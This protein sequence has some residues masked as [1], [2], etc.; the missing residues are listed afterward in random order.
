M[1]HLS[2]A[3]LLADHL[4][5]A[6]TTIPDK[7]AIV[8]NGERWTWSTLNE[9]V[10]RLAAALIALNVQHGDRIGILSTTRP[11]YLYVYL[12]AARIGAVLVGFNIQFTPAEITRLA[13][14][15]RPVVMVAVDRVKGVPFAK[16]LLDL[17]ARLDYVKHVLVIG[18]TIP[19][20]LSVS[21]IIKSP[22]EPA[23][24][25]ALAE[26]A[27]LL[28]PD[29]PVLIVFTSGS[30]G[31]PKGAVLTHR[32]ILTTGRVQARQFGLRPSDRVLQNKP[33]NHVGGSINLTIP[34]LIVGATLVFMDHFHPIRALEMVRDE[35]ITVLA[36]VPTMF[37]MEFNLPDFADYDLSSVRLAIVGGA[38]TPVPIMHRIMDIAET[39]ITGFGMTE[40]GGYI[41][42][43]SPD[44]PPE[45]I[46][47][48]VGR[49]A[50]EYELRIVD[51]A[52]QP[53]PPGSVG[54]VALRGDCLLK[55][56]F[57]DP[58]ATI[59][60]RDEEGW[61]YTGDVGTL[62]VHGYLSLV[63]RLKEMYISG[64]YNVYP[65]EIEQHLAQYPGV[66]MVAV[67]G[68]TDPVMG[69]VGVAFVTLMPG[70][71]AADDDLRQFCASGLAEYKIPRRFQVID[72]F[73]LTPLGKIDKPRL[74]KEWL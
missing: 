26:R 44:D 7:E 5:Q 17:F 22:L 28:D 49:I 35:R 74:R 1:P 60:S 12:A 13:D 38:A 69:E 45:V 31:T 23:A 36:Q 25:A 73:P 65:R 58:L 62:D 16:S 68:T 6:S 66:S 70:A 19:A 29:D 32:S 34:A 15:T 55:A 48:T 72:R 42:F 41:T 53:L 37:I 30:T 64:G 50:D 10:E 67:L 14:I 52:R 3:A 27:T 4:I 71:Q 54:E 61:F 47:S 57:N 2:A 43:T 24:R 9:H 11:E 40:T 18:E 51:E 63:D 46:A 8:Y 20:A 39:V 33:M 21:E 56:Y 59:E